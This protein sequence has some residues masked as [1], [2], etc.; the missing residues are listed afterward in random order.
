[1]AQNGSKWIQMS[2]NRPKWLKMDPNGSKW[3]QMDPNE[4]KSSQMAPNGL[5]CIQ[6]HPN[7]SKWIQ[8]GPPETDVSAR[9]SL[10]RLCMLIW[11]NTLRRVH[12]VGFLLGRLIL[13]TTVTNTLRF[14]F[15]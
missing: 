8:M 10:R 15:P 14:V 4:S 1:M 2:P 3:I 5:K 7:G 9:I 13:S 6:M 11:I 12:N